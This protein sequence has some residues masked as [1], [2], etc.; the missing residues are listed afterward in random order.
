[1][2]NISYIVTIAIF[3]CQHYATY[4]RSKDKTTPHVM[5]SSKNESN[6]F[7]I[8]SPDVQPATSTRTTNPSNPPSTDQVEPRM[9]VQADEDPKFVVIAEHFQNIICCSITLYAISP[10]TYILTYFL[11]LLPIRS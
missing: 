8:F 6:C 7:N 3:L 4:D 2:S 9:P 10:Y 5:D 11:P 1:M